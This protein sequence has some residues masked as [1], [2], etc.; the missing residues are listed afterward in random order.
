M[1]SESHFGTPGCTGRRSEPNAVNDKAP[2]K[3]RRESAPRGLWSSPLKW[4]YGFGW[5]N[6]W[7]YWASDEAWHH[8]IF[9]WLPALLWPIH[10]VG[11]ILSWALAS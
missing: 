11:A 7:I 3:K 9:G 10:V 6:D 5:I 4:I 1:T 8:I 2:E